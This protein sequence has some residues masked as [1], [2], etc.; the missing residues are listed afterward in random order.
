MMAKL[1]AVDLRPH[2][3]TDLCA[4][5]TSVARLN[6]IVLRA[7]TANQLTYHLLADSASAVYLLACLIDS[8]A[9]FGGRL[10]ETGYLV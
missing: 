3:F 6:S 4:A 1:C 7:D 2:R 9:E 10:A 8:A 5:Q